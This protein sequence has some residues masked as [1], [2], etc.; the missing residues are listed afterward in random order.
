[1]ARPSHLRYHYPPGLAACT[2]WAALCGR[3]RS[4]PADAAQLAST[5]S[6]PPQVHGLEHIPLAGSFVTVFNHYYSPRFASWWAAIV[7]TALIQRRR[8]LGAGDVCWVMTA[9]WTYADP[10]RQHTLTPLTR[11]AFGRV[12]RIYGLVAMPP[13]PPRP[14]EVEARA[15]AVRQLLAIASR[16]RPPL[17][18]LSPEGHDG[19]GARLLVPPAGVGRL[20]LLLAA[21]GVPFL[22]V[23]LCEDG[24]TLNVRFGP[25]L[26][27]QAPTGLTR[28][29]RDVWASEQIMVAI[30][31]QLPPALWGAYRRPLAGE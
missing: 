28:S 22:P 5:L 11:W 18:G 2:V 10:L 20:L 23:G 24:D 9:A 14:H 15:R 27:L 1:M 26:R 25:P 4:F 19:P 13:M 6:P 17:I 31:R 7:I 16:E 3:R 8:L 29:G 12:A 30:G 21:T